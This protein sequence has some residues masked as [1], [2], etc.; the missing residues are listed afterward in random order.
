MVDQLSKG[1]AQL[2][3][4]KSAAEPDTQTISELESKL[5]QLGEELQKAK[6]KTLM[7]KFLVDGNPVSQEL[8]LG[9]WDKLY[10]SADQGKLKV[11]GATANHNAYGVI[12][13]LLLCATLAY[14]AMRKP[15]ENNN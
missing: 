6:S 2:R 7:A 9:K 10:L 5:N 14:F 13:F 3:T 15:P 8:T 4:L 11:S 12:A 1:K